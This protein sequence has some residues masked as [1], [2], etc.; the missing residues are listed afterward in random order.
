[1]TRRRLRGTPVGT[2]FLL[3][4]AAGCAVHAPGDSPTPSGGIGGTVTAGPTCPVEKVPADPSCAP[5]V[6]GGAVLVVRDGSG[7]EVGRVSSGTDGTFFLPLGAG[8]YVV[9][10]QR[11]EGLLGVAPEQTVDVAAG[12]RSNIVL[13]YDSGIRGPVSAP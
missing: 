12:T 4:V 3:L 11:V 2:T 7:V 9:V 13:V 1:M 10:P 6:I 8:S 5:R